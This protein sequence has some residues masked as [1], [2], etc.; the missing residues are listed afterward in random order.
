[1]RVGAVAVTAEAVDAVDAAETAAVAQDPA[2]FRLD[3]TVEGLV[4][5][6]VRDPSL[7]SLLID[8][9]RG[10]VGWRGGERARQERLVRACRV[11][12]DPVPHIVDGTGGLGTDAW[13]LASAGARVVVVEQHAVLRALLADGLARAMREAPEVCARITLA[14]G[15]TRRDVGAFAP[16][17][18]YLDPMYPPRRKQALGDR[19]LRCVGALLEADGLRGD[20]VA[21]LVRG[22]LDAG[23]PRVVLK[24]PRKVRLEGLPPPHHALE[25]R[26]TR[27]DVWLSPRASTAR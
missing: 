1:M 16:D 20:D 23:V 3:R 6:A 10:S 2:A 15:D 11:A 18:L 7:G 27:F 17:V 8:F 5:V 21:G 12:A 9:T 4:L 19:R 14:A 26:S 22:G 13:L 25:G 24:C